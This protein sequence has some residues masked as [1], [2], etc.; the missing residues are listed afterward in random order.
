MGHQVV[1]LVLGVGLGAG[2]LIVARLS[3]KTITP[4]TQH[5]GLVIVAGSLFVRLAVAAAS[6]FAYRHFFPEGFILFAIGLAGGFLVLYT[7]ELLKYSGILA[8]A[9]CWRKE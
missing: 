3:T 1:A 6:L 8:R 7:V 9:R 2:M 5:T 4:E